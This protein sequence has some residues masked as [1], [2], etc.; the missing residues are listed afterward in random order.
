MSIDAKELLGYQKNGK[1]RLK[2]KSN[3]ADEVILGIPAFK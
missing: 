2:L 3:D 1:C